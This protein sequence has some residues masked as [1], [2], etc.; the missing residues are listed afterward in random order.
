MQRYV[1]SVLSRWDGPGGITAFTVIGRPLQFGQ[2]RIGISISG[3]ICAM[4]GICLPQ[5]KEALPINSKGPVKFLM[6][7]K[8][9]ADPGQ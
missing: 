4:L 7:G 8:T 3:W 2:V 1:T 5:F 6:V 9:G